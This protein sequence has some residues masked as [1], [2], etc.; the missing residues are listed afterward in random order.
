MIEH[1]AEWAGA[2]RVFALPYAT[3][4]DLEEAC[5]CG[6]GT[7]ASRVSSMDF[8]A[9]EVLSVVRFGLIGGSM[10]KA[11]AD[12]LM[13]ARS[14]TTPFVEWVALAAAILNARMSGVPDAGTA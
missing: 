13:A 10:D 1:R 4:L 14:D 7:L 11:E 9:K 2:E 6:F 8:R 12:R 3:I 5:G